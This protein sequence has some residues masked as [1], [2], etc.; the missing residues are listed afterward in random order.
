MS[1]HTSYT[2]TTRGMEVPRDSSQSPTESEMLTQ[3]HQEWLSHQDTRKF[4]T[5]VSDSIYSL[6]S[7]AID[8]AGTYHVHG[9]HIQII[10]LLNRAAELRK[11]I[12]KYAQ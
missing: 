3:I 7:Q 6:I 9:N 11:V 2:S 8:L 10:L 5:E 4:K 1:I 12:E